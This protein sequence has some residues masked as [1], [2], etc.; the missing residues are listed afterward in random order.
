MIGGGLLGLEAAYGLAKAGTQVSVIHLM[1]RLMERQLDPRASLMLKAELEARGIKV[2]LEANTAAVHGK[3]RVEAVELADGRLLEADVVIVAAG[4]R[5]NVDLAQTADLAIGRGV[6]VD[7]QLRSS[8]DG[9]YALGECAEH[10]G[11]CYG[12][13]EPAYEQARVL[14]SHLAGGEA[15]YTGSVLATNLKV[16]GV[17]LFSAG[18]FLGQ[19]GSEQIVL[20]DP[21]LRS[22]R[23]LVIRDGQAHRRGAVRR[24]G[25]RALVSRSDPQ[26]RA[27]R[28]DPQR[29]DVRPRAGGAIRRPGEGGLRAKHGQRIQHR[30]EA[31]S[32]RLCLR[33]HR[34]AQ[35]P[36][37][38]AGHGRGDAERPRR[39]PH[40]G[41][42]P[43]AGLGPQAQ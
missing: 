7:D 5:P 14:A 25:G 15:S 9:I 34:G 33:R 13:V 27:D 31:L 38:A 2:H 26:R 40:R 28:R 10:R 41:A 16:S 29:H 21:G 24:Y 12:L 1:D 37:D 22:Y 4:I 39:D 43:R 19:P 11:I 17:N 18:D 8:R 35:R 3:D 30:P 42:E 23:K 6:S 20:S 36:R 32:R